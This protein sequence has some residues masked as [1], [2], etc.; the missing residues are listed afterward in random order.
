MDM[1]IWKFL[2]YLVYFSIPTVS[3]GSGS[4]CGI[5]SGEI[6]LY[7]PVTHHCCDA[8][9]HTCCDDGFAC[10]RGLCISIVVTIFI[11]SGIC[12]VIIFLIIVK[13]IRKRRVSN[14]TRTT[15][16][17]IQRTEGADNV[18]VY[19]YC[20]FILLAVKTFFKRIRNKIIN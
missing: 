19:K 14:D 16:G 3:D 17:L 13:A 18:I 20:K 6:A 1:Q 5:I 15:R 8:T 9:L 11:I 4:A 12:F 2:L 10:L 7:C